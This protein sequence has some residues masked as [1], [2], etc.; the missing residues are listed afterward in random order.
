[1][2]RKFYKTRRA[3]KAR[4]VSNQSGQ[5]VHGV[6]GNAVV[7]D[8]KVAVVS[9]GIAGGTHAGDL[10]ALIDVLPHGYQQTG[11]VAVISHIAVAVVDLHQ[12]AIAAHPSGVSHRA[13][14]G[15]ADGSTIP[16]GNINS[17]VVSGC[18][19]VTEMPITERGGDVPG[20]RPA[21]GTGGKPCGP[22][23]GAL[24]PLL[25]D[26]VFQ[27]D[28]GQHHPRRFLA[29]YIGDIGHHIGRPVGT[30]GNNLVIALIEIGAVC[31]LH[32]VGKSVHIP[33]LLHHG[34]R[35]IGDGGGQG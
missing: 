12:I 4:R 22:I 23:L 13:A 2:K 16:V 5:I 11:V 3:Q 14:V 1:M 26:G 30:R 24:E 7:A 9:G 31:I 25:R 21:E 6:T 20:A 15:G 8:L 32:V 10:L 35:E 29:V 19:A 28:G 33:F 34:H 27:R 17:L 18:I